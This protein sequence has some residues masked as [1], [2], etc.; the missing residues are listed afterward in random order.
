MGR[1]REQLD[2]FARVITECIGTVLHYALDLWRRIN[3][4]C[5]FTISQK[6]LELPITAILCDGKHFQFFEFTKQKG[7]NGGEQQ[8]P[9]FSFPL[10]KFDD[11]DGSQ[12]VAVASPSRWEPAPDTQTLVL[13]IRFA[14]EALYFVFLRAYKNSLEACLM[15]H[16]VGQSKA[17][18]ETTPI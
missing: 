5:S 16:S 11:D 3:A 17:E 4:P 18:S 8:S 9:R 1:V 7:K 12:S 13:Q 10:G 2:Y 14:C 15:N 6:G